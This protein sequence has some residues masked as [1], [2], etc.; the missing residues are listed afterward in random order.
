MHGLTKEEKA[1]DPNSVRP[2]NYQIPPDFLTNPQ[3]F[4]KGT[5]WQDV[6]FRDAP[7]DNV[8]L[9]VSGG[10]EK[11]KLFAFRRIHQPKWNR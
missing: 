10:N 1:S 5:D 6:L 9:S 7:S 3:Q 11:N 4:G 8:Q 2:Q